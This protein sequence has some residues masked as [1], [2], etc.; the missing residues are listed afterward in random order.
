MQFTCPPALR[1]H[2][3]P[4]VFGD[5]LVRTLPAHAAAA[6]RLPDDV[7]L[8]YIGH[9]QR[10]QIV[11]LRCWRRLTEGIDGGMFQATHGGG[12]F[13]FWWEDLAGSLMCARSTLDELLSE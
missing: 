7:W 4:P 5:P 8:H 1:R 9:E 6:V 3:P 10:H 12:Q 11:C 2:E 13:P